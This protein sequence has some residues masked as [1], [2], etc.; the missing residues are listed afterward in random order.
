MRSFCSVVVVALLSVPAVAQVQ[1]RP[2]DPPSVTAED[3]AWYGRGEPIQFAGN[4]YRRAGAAVFFDGNRMVRS[5][6]FG[7]VPVYTDTTLEPYSV[8]FVPIRRGLMQP[9]ELP[10]SGNL[11]GTTGSTAPSFPVSAL[12]D[13]WT[14]PMAPSAP[15]G[16]GPVPLV[17]AE[18]DPAA[19]LTP[20]LI[21]ASQQA[22]VSAPFE[23][24][25]PRPI[26]P[27]LTPV[28]MQKA[29]EKVWVE[30]RGEKWIPAGPAI[31]FENSGLMQTGEYAGFPVFS[32]AGQDA[33]IFLPGLPGLV[34]PYELKR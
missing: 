16:L 32:Y 15:T 6:Y 17:A 14:P 7:G 29:R 1:S 26:A 21:P 18:A 23:N 4:L 30:Y 28:E 5:G 10:R 8:V 33:R 22:E 3:A 27:P 13:G 20:T 24:P 34:A 2:T 31:P 25:L 11:A 19:V 12:P 9:Y